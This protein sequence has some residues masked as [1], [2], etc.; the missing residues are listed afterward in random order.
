VGRPQLDE[1]TKRENI[2]KLINCARSLMDERGIQNVTIRAIADRAEMNSATMYNYF[3]DLDEL[4]TYACISYFQEYCERL[5]AE[6]QYL[7]ENEPEEVYLMTWD[8]FCQYAFIHPEEMYQLFF[9]KYSGELKTV[10]RKYYQW[11]PEETENLSQNL[12]EMME[13]ADMFK[14][15]IH[16][17][18]PIL[19]EGT[20]EKDLKIVNELTVSYLQMLLREL[21]EDQRGRYTPEGQK[22]RMMEACVFLLDNITESQNDEK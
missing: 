4:I 21:S 1:K 9:G 18:R 6:N 14:R 17:L 5:Y 12:Q 15:N 7:S 3:R 11:F 2:K 22:Q 16:V 13:D 10:I 8:L 20:S 19:P